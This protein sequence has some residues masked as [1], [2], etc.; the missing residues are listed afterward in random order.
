MAALYCFWAQLSPRGGGSVAARGLGSMT[1][2]GL[3]SMAA[4]GLC[5]EADA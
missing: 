3:G 2:R 5:L 4:S 1:A